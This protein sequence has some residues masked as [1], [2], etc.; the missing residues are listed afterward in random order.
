MIES[1]E[2]MVGNW[3]DSAFLG[4][5]LPVTA[6][7]S[8][9]GVVKLEGCDD[10]FDYS[11]IDPILL[12]PEILTEKFNI[13]SKYSCDVCMDVTINGYDTAPLC[14]FTEIK[15]VHTLQN[16]LTALGKPVEIEL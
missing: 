7:D 8:E 16:L 1:K 3:V 9:E 13:Q 4:C 14:F 5:E 11:D 6:I 15:Y 10:P 12:T 2:L